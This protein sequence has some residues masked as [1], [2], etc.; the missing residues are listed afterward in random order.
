[1]AAAATILDVAKLAQVSPSTVTHALNGKRPVNSE[2]KNRILAAIDALS[3]V[4]S[5]NASR[6]R[7]GKTGVIGCFVID[8]TVPHAN[9][10]VKGIESGLA[11]SD[12][13]M[14]FVSGVEFGNDFSKAYQFFLSRNI[15]G[16]LLC[17]YL[18]VLQHPI[19]EMFSSPF[20]I[21]AINMQV[22]GITSV[23]L[24]NTGGGMQAADHL[25]AAGMSCPAMICGPAARLSTIQ[26]L[27]GFQT[28]LRARGLDV[29]ENRAIYGDYT[30]EHG[31]RAALELIRREKNIDGIFCANDDIAAGAISRL[32]SAG[33]RVPDDI[34]VLGC[35]NRDFS[36]FWPVPI[37]TFELPFEEM[38]LLGLNTLCGAMSS[39]ASGGESSVLR[40]KLIVRAST[41]RLPTT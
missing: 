40:P 16:L 36:A 41:V 13:S 2:T 10:I 17:H 7:T 20:P 3:Y 14:L 6:L 33:Y 22:E 31:S 34:R 38:G 12:L 4:P 19:K 1:M 5:H 24:D 15:E 30:Y 27:D 37:S 32:T 39:A 11:G 25:C 18:A 21:V 8:I 28:R 23:M 9:R 35:D 29:P 26:R